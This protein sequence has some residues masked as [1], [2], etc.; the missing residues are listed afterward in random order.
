MKALVVAVALGAA[1]APAAADDTADR[2]ARA[3]ALVDEASAA[4]KRADYAT[5]I[6]KLRE[7][8]ELI[9]H[10]DLLYNLGQ[11]YRLAEQPWDAMEQYERYLALEPKGRAAAKARTYLKQLRKQTEGQTRPVEPPPTT[12]V[13][14]P[15]VEPPPVEEARQPPVE[16]APP[17]APPRAGAD[18]P[19][20]R[21]P[22][23]ITLGVLGLAAIGVGVYAGLE[24]RTISDDLSAHDGP[25]TDALLARQAE[26]RDAETR[27]IWLSAAG[28]ALVLGG[29]VLF[30]IDAS[31]RGRAA[32]RR[33]AVLPVAGADTLGLA[34]RGAY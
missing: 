4:E 9:P 18:V 24:A 13:E 12:T 32:D 31:A 26:G 3:A 34:V 17:P 10:P 20:W 2:K 27:A 25:W 6:A 16:E 7:A 28:G 33:V 19:G 29:V 11:A 23:A 14:P 8:Y 30:A 15:P 22:T 1:A 21:R 5:A